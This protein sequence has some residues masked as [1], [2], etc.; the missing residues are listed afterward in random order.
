[1][2]SQGIGFGKVILFGEHFVVY[3]LPAIAS[4]IDS[5]TVATV[6]KSKS[7]ELVDNRPETPG[8]K[9]EKFSQ[10]EESL[11]IIFNTMKIDP[12]KTPVK[13]VLGGDLVAASGLGASA[14]SCVAIA[15]ALSKEFGLGL[16]DEQINS[17]AYEGEKGYHGTPSGIDNTAATYG[18]L[19]W[20]WK[21]TPPVMERIPLRQ[22]VEIVM[23]DTG[24][25]ANTTE[26][27]G[28]V[29]KRKEAEPEKFKKIFME[30]E[31]LLA[32]AR[33]ALEAMDLQRVGKL[34]DR[35]HELLRE[36]G[37]SCKELE[38]LVD[39]AR[40]AGAVGA[41]ITGTGRGGNVVA[42]TPGKALQEKVA[43]AVEAKGFR[44]LRIR[45]GI[46]HA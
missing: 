42:L 17:V 1:M 30:E 36:I 19:I 21:G 29:K 44:A 38:T 18:G 32:D 11:K 37:V 3:G 4:A 13:I 43:K 2:S 45:I 14:A 34:M 22:P 7:Y 6:E 16:N 9:K 24:I 8:Y 41:K 15:R 33:A 39:T 27:V 46:K 31:K 26:V 20:F 12:V 10:Q 28:G 25:T 5:R 40:G 23:A 35:N